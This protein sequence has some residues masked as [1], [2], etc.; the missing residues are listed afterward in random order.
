MPNLN[1]KILSDVPVT[2]PPRD[3]QR[4]IASVLGSLDDKIELNRRIAKTLEQIAATIFKARFVDFVGVEEFEESEL[5]LIP[6][7]WSVCEL[8]DLAHE[9]TEIVKGDDDRPYIGLDAM[10][11]ASTVL[12]EWRTEG[13]P[14]GQA[15]LFQ[16]NDIL[17]GKLRPYFKKVGPAPID[18]RCSTEILAF[19]TEDEDWGFVL[20]HL[21]SQAFID[22]AVRVS[23]GTRMPRAEWKVAGKYRVAVP[24]REDRR[25]FS[26]IARTC[27]ERIHASTRESQALVAIRDSLLPKL[28]SGQL[29][30]PEGFG[31]DEAAEVADGLVESEGQELAA[32]TATSAA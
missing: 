29:R 9:R 27:Y 5:G 17:F 12:D 7:G 20:G 11:R 14:R 24:P 26:E 4:R 18:G 1:T 13:A 30:V 32:K 8:A 10:P 31:P 6:K 19:R 28:I 16:Q 15:R 3:E 2:Y 21:A 22:H 25:E 23:S